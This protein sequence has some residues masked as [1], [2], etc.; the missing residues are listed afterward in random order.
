MADQPPPA[1][2]DLP[3]S[4]GAA[5]AHGCCGGRIRPAPLPASPV[6]PIEILPLAPDRTQAEQTKTTEQSTD[7][8]P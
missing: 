6:Q 3:I 4:R 7:T 1:D 5:L 2:N 8:R